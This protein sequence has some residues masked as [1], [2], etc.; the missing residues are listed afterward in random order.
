MRVEWTEPAID[1]L[2]AIR[3][4]I[5]KDSPP[6]A[7]LFIERLFDAAQPLADHPLIGRHVPEAI[8][9]QGIRELIYQNYRLIYRVHNDRV[10]ILAVIHARRD[11]AGAASPPWET[12]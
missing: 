1:D 7:R 4:F 6:Y 10:S 12:R 11:L 3:D 5:A 9:H 2:I 8:G